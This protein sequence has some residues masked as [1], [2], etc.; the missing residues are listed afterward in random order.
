MLRDAEKVRIKMI[1]VSLQDCDKAIELEPTF[2]KAYLR[3]AKV[4]Q[5]MSQPSK[6]IAA[7]E[8]V[9]EMDPNCTEAVEGY[10]NCSIQVPIRR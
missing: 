4:L 9:L 2:V 6:A 3:K 5:G 7:Y 10:K 8:K 1:S